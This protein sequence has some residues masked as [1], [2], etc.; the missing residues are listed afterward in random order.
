MPVWLKDVAS[1]K[2]WTELVA[3][4]EYKGTS[5]DFGKSSKAEKTALWYVLLGKKQ[6]LLN[7][8]RQES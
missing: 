8:Y 1:L 2:Q 4:G 6:S 7:L 5:D 3:K